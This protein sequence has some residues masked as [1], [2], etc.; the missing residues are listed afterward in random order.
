NEA[1]IKYERLGNNEVLLHHTE[2]PKQFRSTGIAKELATEV[3]KYFDETRQKM[4]ITC[5][6]L[7]KM[8]KKRKEIN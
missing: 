7:Q 2:V 3:F 1:F 8:D 6:Y 4:I 5:T